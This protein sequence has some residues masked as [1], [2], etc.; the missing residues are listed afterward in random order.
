MTLPLLRATGEAALANTGDHVDS[1]ILLNTSIMNLS[2]SG[3]QDPTK[4]DLR[5]VAMHELV[6]VLGAGGAGSSLLSSQV[7]PMDLFR[8]SAKNVA[9]YTTDPTAKA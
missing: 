9:S 3:P 6:E 5:Q 7:G 2:R 8:Y 4:Y 1:T